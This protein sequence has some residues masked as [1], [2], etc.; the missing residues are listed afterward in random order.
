MDA[1]LWTALRALEERA[2]LSRELGLRSG[3]DVGPE[4]VDRYTAR[5]DDIDRAADQI[6]RVLG[7]IGYRE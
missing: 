5:A 6:R 2:V 7:E 4:V 1:A 3:P